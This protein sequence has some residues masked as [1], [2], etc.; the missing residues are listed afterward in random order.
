V[1]HA[2]HSAVNFMVGY[3]KQL[4]TRFVGLGF[5]LFRCFL[6]CENYSH[7]KILPKTMS[8]KCVVS[9]FVFCFI[10]VGMI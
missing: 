6:V 2:G 7:G 9:L 3:C 10:A 5:W 1:P 4:K 8:K